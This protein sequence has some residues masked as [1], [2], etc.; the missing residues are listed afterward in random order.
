MEQG[1]NGTGPEHKAGSTWKSYMM[2]LVCDA[3]QSDLLADCSCKVSGEYRKTM[4]RLQ[5]AS[6]QS[7]GLSHYKCLWLTWLHSMQ[8]GRQAP[9]E[10]SLSQALY[11]SWVQA[12]PM[13]R[14]AKD[15]FHTEYHKRD[16]SLAAAVKDW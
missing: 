13:S 3:V 16:K 10:S 7:F 9:E 12:G 14:P 5:T 2:H 1:L 6:W 11:R 4:P 8:V 15:A